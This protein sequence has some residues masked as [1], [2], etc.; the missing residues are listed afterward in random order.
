MSNDKVEDEVSVESGKAL[1]QV[2][3]GDHVTF[4]RST[5]MS[6]PLPCPQQRS[7]RLHRKAEIPQSTSA[8]LPPDM[9]Q[10]PSTSAEM[11]QPQP[12]TSPSSFS[13][14]LLTERSAR[15]RHV[16]PS[17]LERTLPPELVPFPRHLLPFQAL[18]PPYHEQA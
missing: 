5:Q 14:T 2:T 15:H 6:Q 18:P 9:H 11:P 13:R 17:P 12:S 7:T 16:G 8:A 3:F 1:V 4:A 10:A